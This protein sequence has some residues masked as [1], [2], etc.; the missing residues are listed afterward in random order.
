MFPI[1]ME[2]NGSDEDFGLLRT[3]LRLSV[4]C[5]WDGFQV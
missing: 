1:P 2:P 4:L 5:V 3:Q